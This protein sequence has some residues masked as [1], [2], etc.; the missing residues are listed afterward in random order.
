MYCVVNVNLLFLTIAKQY[1]SVFFIFYDGLL[2]AHA[3][4]HMQ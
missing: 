1:F 2:T 3:P 4:T